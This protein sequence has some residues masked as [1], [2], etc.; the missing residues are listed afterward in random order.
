MKLALSFAD[1]WAAENSYSQIKFIPLLGDYTQIPLPKV[2][3]LHLTNP[4]WMQLPNWDQYSQRKETAKILERISSL[5]ETGLVITTYFLKEMDF[6]KEE[7]SSEFKL[8]NTRKNGYRYYFADGSDPG[9]KNPKI[10][11]LKSKEQQSCT[12]VFAHKK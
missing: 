5:S 1:E 2:K 8:T 11:I 6:L 7:I 10:F 3:S 12:S 4:T 9:Y